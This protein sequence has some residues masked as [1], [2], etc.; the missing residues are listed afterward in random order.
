M[1]ALADR[2]QQDHRRDAD[3]NAEQGQEAAQAVRGDRAQG[4]EQGVAGAD[5]LSGKDSL[6][7][8]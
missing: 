4:K 7:V 6:W 8:V 1:D 5:H 3:G 2:R